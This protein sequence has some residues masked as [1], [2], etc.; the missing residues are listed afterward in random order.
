M[1]QTS[2]KVT[3][4]KIKLVGERTQGRGHSTSGEC[5]LENDNKNCE[6]GKERNVHLWDGA[7]STTTNLKC[8]APKAV[9]CLELWHQPGRD[10]EGEILSHT[11]THTP[12]LTHSLSHTHTLTH[13][14]R[15][16]H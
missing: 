6:S 13:F 5:R 12:I 9:K 11:H 1:N 2:P 8:R 15:P 16:P 10:I 14:V 7:S 3:R 4:K